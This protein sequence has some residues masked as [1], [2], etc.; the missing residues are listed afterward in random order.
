M[1]V[2]LWSRS[3]LND[4][5]KIHDYIATFNP[6]AGR[7]MVERIVS[8]AESLA[9]FPHRR[10]PVRGKDLRESTLIYPYIIRYRVSGDEVFVLRVRHG[11]RRPLA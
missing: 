11:N 2:V 1:A 9:A 7:T 8:E 4:L 5:E 10:R 3:A 6:S